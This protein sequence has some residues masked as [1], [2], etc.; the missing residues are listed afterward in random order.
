MGTEGIPPPQ[1]PKR[2]FFFG[3]STLA[4]ALAAGA[5]A[6]AGGALGAGGR[7]LR[8]LFGNFGGAQGGVPLLA[9]GIIGPL[10]PRG[11]LALGLPAFSAFQRKKRKKHTPKE[12]RTI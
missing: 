5:G 9:M 1:K 6:L 4:G 12:R 11:L 8:L 7:L 3:G 2:P 10:L